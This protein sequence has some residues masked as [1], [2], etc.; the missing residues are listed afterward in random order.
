[1]HRVGQLG[2]S[3]MAM[4]FGLQHGFFQPRYQLAEPL[5]QIALAQDFAHLMQAALDCW[6]GA[7][8]R[9]AAAY[10]TA[11][12]QVDALLPAGILLLLPLSQLKVLFLP[13]LSFFAHLGSNTCTG[14]QSP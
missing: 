8:H 14:K 10:K 7:F 13:T 5:V 12:Q 1:M 6:V 4:T 2:G 9:E 11:P 3:L